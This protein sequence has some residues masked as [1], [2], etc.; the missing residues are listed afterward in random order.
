MKNPGVGEVIKGYKILEEFRMAGGGTCQWTFAHK[1][2][3]DYFIK[4]FLNPRLPRPDGPGSEKV[5]EERRERCRIFERDQ[6]ALMSRVEVTVKAGGNLIAPIDFFEHDGQYFKVSPKVTVSGGIAASMPSQ[7]ISARI[8]LCLN[9]CTAL[10]SLHN[11]SIVHGDLKLDNILIEKHSDTFTAKVIDFDSSYVVGNVPKSTEIMGD[12]PYYSPELLNYIQEK[13]AADKLTT[14]SDIFSL[15]I[16]FCEYLTGS[17]PKWSGS[18]GYMAEAV[19]AGETILIDPIP[20]SD[21]RSKALEALLRQTLALEPSDRPGLTMLKNSLKSIRDRTGS[22][23]P[24]PPPPTRHDVDSLKAQI[25]ELL[26]KVPAEGGP[27]GASRLKGSLAPK[28][29]N[30]ATAETLSRIVEQLRSITK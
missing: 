24:V 29:D 14:S 16:A 12:P 22:T 20:H 27:E 19:R 26:E 25:R 7:P 1:D 21:G 3:R 2:G 23:P 18:H 8:T 17:K 11:N 5:K 30:G 4:V 13:A 15:G 6:R 9:V 10:Q 28:K